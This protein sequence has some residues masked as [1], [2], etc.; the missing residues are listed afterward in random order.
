M[1]ALRFSDI[2]HA[3]GT[4]PALRAFSLGVED[5]E[6]VSLLGPSGSGKTTALRIAAGLET[7]QRGTV[8]V[9]EKRVFG[10]GINVPT[11][12][13]DV[14]LLFQD[15]ALFPHLTVA[16]N[17]GFGLRG[18]SKARRARVGELLELVGLGAHARVYPH[19]LSGGQQQRVALARALAPKPSVL[20]LDEPFSNLDVVLRQ[21][22]RREM[23]DLLKKT[24]TSV[25][26]VTHDPEEALYISD[27][28]AVMRDG[29]IVQVAAPEALYLAPANRFVASFFG[30]TNVIPATVRD[31]HATTP[32]GSIAATGLGDGVAAD[33]LVRAQGLLVSKASGTAHAVVRSAR[34][35]GAAILLELEP[36]PET[37]LTAPLV[38][39]AAMGTHPQAGER[40]SLA[41]DPQF[42]FAFARD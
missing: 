42:A 6:I 1:T 28:V 12:A 32:F 17:V 40:V 4:R 22:V 26:L 20:L 7:P 15:L 30:H 27:R 25:L 34:I 3:Y 41:L 39:R 2:D 21:Q 10:D 38:A 11:E 33:V 29:T 35:L 37:G 5:G 13:R 23:A 14:G 9:G 16:E 31:G 24:G 8:H 18:G 19:Q 36:L